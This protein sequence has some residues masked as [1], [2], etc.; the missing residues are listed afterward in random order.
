MPRLRAVQLRGA[1]RGAVGHLRAGEQGA[2]GD[3]P[4]EGPRAGQGQAPRRLLPL[5]RA[6]LQAPQGEAGGAQ[7]ALQRRGAAATGGRGVCR[8]EPL[9]QELPHARRPDRLVVGCPGE[10]KGG[11]QADVLPARAADPQA[12]GAHAHGAGQ[13]GARRCRLLL[14]PPPLCT[15]LR[16]LCPWAGA[17]QAHQHVGEGVQRGPEQQQGERQAGH[18]RR[19][20]P[21]VQG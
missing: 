4:Q 9:L 16:P 17:E 7:G 15:A 6:A 20:C 10:A 19:D 1:G 18:G 11:P 21:P 8:Q 2:D 14:P 3:M 13:G 5:D 12:Q